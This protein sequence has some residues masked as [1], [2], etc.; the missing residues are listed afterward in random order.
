M[1]K[2]PKCWTI[3]ALDRDPNHP[4][5]RRDAC[6]ANE[7]LFDEHD[8]ADKRSKLR[9]GTKALEMRTVVTVYVALPTFLILMSTCAHGVANEDALGLPHTSLTRVPN[10]MLPQIPIVEDQR[11]H[12]EL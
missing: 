1:C 2:S 11:L 10:T 9:E 7:Q 6:R 5:G 4:D 3:P 12:H 8:T